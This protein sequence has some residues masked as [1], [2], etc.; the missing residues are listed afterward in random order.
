MILSISDAAQLKKEINEQLSVSIH[1]HDGCGGQYFT[2]D[3]TSEA[4]VRQITE[5]LLEKDLNAVFSE[6]GLQ[7]TVDKN[8][9]SK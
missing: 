7:F 4:V 6:D 8:A 9:H 5:F 1:F 3:E 2:I